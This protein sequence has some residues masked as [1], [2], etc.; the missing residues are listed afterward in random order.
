METTVSNSENQM[1]AIE[2][3]LAAAKARK[4]AK[5]E[6]SDG[7]KGAQTHP[8]APAARKSAGNKELT[9]VQRAAAAAQRETER[10]ARAAAKAA[11]VEAAAA[12]KAAAAAE[13]EAKKAAAAAEKS[14]KT[15][16]HMKKVERARSKCPP[17]ADATSRIY[18]DAASS[19]SALQ[20]EA[21]AAHLVVQ[22]RAM[23][24]AA[25]A[26]TSPI[27]LGTTVSIT[28]GDPKFIGAVGKVVSSNK[29]RLKVAVDGVKSPVYIYVGEAAPVV[30]PVDAAA[31]A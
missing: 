30:A 16:A 31:A 24:T 12:A 25:A 14:N 6:G 27:A 18:D 22:A 20:M 23:R 3:A 29:L 8:A 17:M 1:T 9:D 5:G 15:P 28:G 7:Q 10:A 19:L 11:A 2:R 13:R 21:L 4:A 26:A